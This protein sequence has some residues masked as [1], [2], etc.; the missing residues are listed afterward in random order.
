MSQ[1]LPVV[2]MGSIPHIYPP[3]ADLSACGFP[4]PG[5]PHEIALFGVR[6]GRNGF[7]INGIKNTKASNRV[8]ISGGGFIIGTFWKHLFLVSSGRLGLS[9]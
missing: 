9:D 7:R 4:A 6:S 3:K 2:A 8:K 1:P 5:G